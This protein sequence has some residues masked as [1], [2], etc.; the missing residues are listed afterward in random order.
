M[1]K[2][3]GLVFTQYNNKWKSKRKTGKNRRKDDER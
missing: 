3:R 2:L 1:L